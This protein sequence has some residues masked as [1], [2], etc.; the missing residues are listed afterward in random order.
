MI[1]RMLHWFTNIRLYFISVVFSYSYFWIALAVPYLSW[2]GLSNLEVF[3]LMSAYQ[4]IGVIIEYPTSIIGDRYGYRPTVI[5]GNLMSAVSM[6]ILVQ[7]GGYWLYFVGLLFNAIGTSLMSGNEQGL[8][9]QISSRV[10]HDTAKRSSIAEFVLFLSSIVG[11]WLGGISYTFALTVSGI[12]MFSTI[13]PLLAIK[14]QRDVDL[15][16]LSTKKIIIDGLKSLADT[17]FQQMFLILA[18]YGGFFFTIKSIFGSFGDIYGYPIEIIGIVVGMGALFRSL[19]SAIYVK[20]DVIPKLPLL[21]LMAIL[22]FFLVVNHPLVVILILLTFQLLVGYVLS[23]IDGD[24]QDLAPDHIRSSLFSF[25]RLIMKLFSSLYLFVY[26]IMVGLDSFVLMMLGVGLA[27]SI[28]IYL[29]R[30]Y[31]RVN[32]S[33]K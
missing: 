23:S 3:S 25:K 1:N 14:P 30:S 15:P 8:L 24:I 10:R 27:M 31:S 11:G 9:K 12:L 5:L 2:R 13:F 22:I 20:Y 21:I 32:L 4:L 19:G 6:F 7:D 16:A 28:T 26:G 33:Q 17:T 18:I 29:T